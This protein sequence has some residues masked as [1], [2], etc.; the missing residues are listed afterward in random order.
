MPQQ[1]AFVGAKKQTTRKQPESN[2][3]A[4]S[5]LPA[6]GQIFQNIFTQSYATAKSIRRSTTATATSK[7]PESNQKATRTQ[8]ESNPQLAKY[9]PTYSITYSTTYSTQYTTA[10]IIRRSTTD[11]AKSKQPKRNLKATRH[12]PESKQQLAKYP[13]KK[14]TTYSTT[15]STTYATAKSIRRSATAT[16]KSKQPESNQNANR[17]QPESNKQLVKYPTNDSTTYSN[18]FHNIGHSNEHS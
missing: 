5:K 12:Q 10:K 9:P 11:T 6:A 17:K 3:K 18:I 16:A 4:T 2:Q 14:R 8:P 1:R 13:T 7:Q 15:Y